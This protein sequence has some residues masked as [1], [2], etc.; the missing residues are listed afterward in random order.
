MLKSA[1]VQRRFG[2]LVGKYVLYLGEEMDGGD[3]VMYRNVG[4]FLRNL[5][6]I[7]LRADMAMESTM[8]GHSGRNF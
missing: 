6:E 2:D 5:P 1:R 3:G 4:A 7:N 8:A